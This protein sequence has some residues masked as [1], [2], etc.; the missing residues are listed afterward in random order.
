LVLI[1]DG[2]AGRPSFSMPHGHGYLG[3]HALYYVPAV[4]VIAL[5]LWWL[6]R[7]I[8]RRIERA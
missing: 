6:G 4:A 2:L 8:D 3:D 5:S 7:S 1:V